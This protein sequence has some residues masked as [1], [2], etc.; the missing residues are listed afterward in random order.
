[1]RHT[2]IILTGPICSGKSIA[3]NY[4]A[5]AYG[6][7]VYRNSDVIKACLAPLGLE[8]ARDDYGEFGTWAWGRWGQDVLVRAHF[9][10]IKSLF[11]AASSENSSSL[12][13]I[14]GTR[15]PQEVVAVQKDFSDVHV[16]ALCADENVRLDR[17]LLRRRA[18]DGTHASTLNALRRL[19]ENPAERGIPEC[20]ALAGIRIDNN[21]PE[22]SA[23]HRLL[24]GVVTDELRYRP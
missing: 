9:S 4:L 8:A 19:E 2:I 16:I 20:V 15:N 1:M 13:V 14:D 7:V 18:L 12:V 21:H 6:A 5:T 24:D 23:L 22:L 11:A 3:A 17:M 10:S